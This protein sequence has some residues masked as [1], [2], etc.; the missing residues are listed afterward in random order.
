[1]AEATIAPVVIVES[2]LAAQ[3]L[4]SLLSRSGWPGRYE[5]APLPWCAS[6]D[7]AFDRLAELAVG[8]RRAPAPR[9]LAARRVQLAQQLFD[10][11]EIAASLGG[12]PKAA[13]DLAGQ[14]VEIFEGWEWLASAQEGESFD[15]GQAGHEAKHLAS[16]LS[17]LRNLQAHNQ[18]PTD[19][20]AWAKAHLTETSP[21]WFCMGR[22]PSAREIAM[23]MTL[24]K[25]ALDE[26]SVWF[27]SPHDAH[28][29]EDPVPQENRRL[30]AA[31]SIEE[32]AWAAAQTILAWRAQGL[33]DIGVV[34]LDRKAVRRLRALME[35][36][37]EALSDRSGWALDTTV[38][39]TAVVG[40]ND[41]LTRHAT[42]QTVLEWIHSP[43]VAQGL[44][45]TWNFDADQ[46]R[47][48][49]AALRGFGRVAS[50]GLQ[51]LLGPGLLPFS[52]RHLQAQVS[53]QRLPAHRWATQLLVGI[54]HSGLELP[55]A[56]DPAGQTVLA[57]LKGLAAQTHGDDCL[58]TAA[59]WRASL[60]A[61]LN[62]ARFIEPSGRAAV[63][64]CSLSS[65]TWQ[66]P[67]A[68]VVV[69][70]QEGRLPER[71]VAQFFEPKRFAEMGLQIPPEELEL[72]R[73]AQF[74]SVWRAAVPLVLIACSD[75]PDSAVEFSSWVELLAL[76]SGPT[77]HRQDAGSVIGRRPLRKDGAINLISDCDPQWRY[78]LPPQ[79]SVSE[80]QDLVDC[81]YRFALQTVM[82]L[83]PIESLKEESPPTD[84]GSLMHLAL[85]GATLR[86]KTVQ[87]W[88]IWL[89]KEI[90]RLL[91]EPFFAD[92]RTKA[93]QLPMPKAI[94]S[95]LRAN[96][97]AMIPGLAKW[98]ANRPETA[99]RTEQDI[100]RRID[101]LGI[102]LK[103]RLDRVEEMPCESLLIDFKTSAAG[104][105]R[106]RVKTGQD[107]VQLA[108]YSWIVGADRA[109]K[110]ATY[111]CISRKEV[112]EIAVTDTVGRSVPEITQE[113]MQRVVSE[114]TAIARGE[115]IQATGL[116]KDKKICTYCNVRG[117]C[118]RTDLKDIE[119][120]E[121]QDQ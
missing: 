55:L 70:A 11:P 110:E 116:L 108:L 51:D 106:A 59:L 94:A 60:N 109:V 68:V 49:D 56:Q 84:I 118:R 91:K 29:R 37:G 82:G 120:E 96:A 18:L 92:R 44:N 74:E 4:K 28:T 113:V 42:T 41:L 114:L 103:G 100:A 58:I 90:D 3:G 86:N 20:A 48:L 121:E 101:G 88:E 6:L 62:Q 25:V 99:V 80:I 12:A 33:D 47:A 35:R 14:W 53:A 77:I 43:F 16:D 21:V 85:A 69:G 52:A 32:S 76:Q 117:V 13:L 23:A 30:I 78:A 72:Q 89:V 64:V 115:P 54:E 111:V 19:R 98:L 15:L 38:A 36:A 40:L 22:A 10:H 34:A 26:I 61:E 83:R 50:V 66:L 31:Q 57:A 93:V 2:P 46:R 63:R 67:Q 45:D 1:M 97:G 17:T 8:A 102:T 87:D 75:K 27:F 71:P 24:F 39:A 9:G 73:F 95:R 81:P 5:G 7:Q 107:D 105:L 65:L 79:L 104:P 119:V 112:E